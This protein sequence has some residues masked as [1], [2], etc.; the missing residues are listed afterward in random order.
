MRASPFFS[1]GAP[2]KTA[3]TSRSRAGTIARMKRLPLALATTM[4]LA[5]GSPAASSPAPAVVLPA[6]TAS[7]LT[8]APSSTTPIPSASPVAG[9]AASSAPSPPPAS[10]PR[11]PWPDECEGAHLDGFRAGSGRCLCSDQGMGIGIGTPSVDC[12]KTAPDGAALKV[13]LVAPARVRPGADVEV[14]VVLTNTGSAPAVFRVE[15]FGNGIRDSRERFGFAAFDPRGAPVPADAGRCDVGGM[16]GGSGGTPSSAGV[17][18]PPGG[19]VTW[20]FAWRTLVHTKTGGEV[21]AVPGQRGMWSQSPCH[22]ADV[23]LAQGTYT[24]HARAPVLPEALAT[25][26]GTARA[27]IEVTASP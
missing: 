19:D 18:L 4:A 21:K 9:A 7:T 1:L 26:L 20:R 5:C 6:A 16:M 23:P 27:T 17:T 25:Q 12:P 2:P 14:Q 10:P 11:K 13:T 8:M 22:E 24:L 15:R 3:W